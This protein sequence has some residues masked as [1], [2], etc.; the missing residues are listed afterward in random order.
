VPAVVGPAVEPG[1]AFLSAHYAGRREVCWCACVTRVR[2]LLEAGP[3]PDNRIMGDMFFWTR[4]ASRGPVGCVPR[5][6]SHYV[7]FRCPM[8][9]MSHGTPPAA[10]AGD[11]R[12]TADE[13]L[14]A[15]RQNG[16]GAAYL[17]RLRADARR[18]IARSAGNQF[19]WNRLRGASRIQA[20]T[21]MAGAIR[22]LSWNPAAWSRVAAALVL[23]RELL[24][25]V[26]LHAAAKRT[27]L[28]LAK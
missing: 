14:E 12:L 5:V 3:Q 2:D 28:G 7:L 21:W 26:L 16:A 17:R 20:W 19:V 8:D 9:N 23:P 1:A 4:L 10:W 6:L 27:Q 13:V 15:S 11:S 22:Y 25:R 18:Y 24:R